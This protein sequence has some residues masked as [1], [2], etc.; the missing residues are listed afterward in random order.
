[1]ALVPIL[2]ALKVAPVV[3][4]EERL[5]LTALAEAADMDGCNAI[6]SDDTLALQALIDSRTVRR[7]RRAMHDRGLLALGD[8]SAA[9]YIRADRRPVV[10]DV[11]VPWSALAPY[12]AE[13]NLERERRGRPPLRPVD[14]PEHPPAPQR[15]KRADAGR[16]RGAKDHNP[17]RPKDGGTSSPPGLPDRPDYQ[18]STGG[19]VVQ[20]G[21]STTPPTLSYDPLPNPPQGGVGAK[22][23][24]PTTA[25]AADLLSALPSP[26]RL[27]RKTVPSLAPLVQ[28]ALLDGWAVVDLVDELTRRPPADMARPGS[29]LR[30]RLEDLPPAPATVPMDDPRDPW[31]GACDPADRRIMDLATEVRRRCP[32]CHP[33]RGRP[34][35]ATA[36]TTPPRPASP[37]PSSS[38]RAAS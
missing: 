17:A 15:R 31:C 14:R 7:R 13:V 25:A 19:L 24:T 34:I 16:S 37:R 4:A 2:W 30:H 21:G 35:T 3:D 5:V 29:V 38:R 12:A 22:D 33:L 1:V 10:F 20:H 9:E 32:E 27:G 11:L 26:W 8:Q 23:P 28:A 6:R 18:S 36:D